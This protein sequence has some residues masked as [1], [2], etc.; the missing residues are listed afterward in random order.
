MPVV[1]T[2]HHRLHD[3]AAEIWLGVRT[4]AADT[5]ERAERIREVLAAQGAT[6]VDAKPQPETAVTSVHD[7]ALLDYLARAW[8]EWEAAGLTDDPERRCH[9]FLRA[10]PRVDFY[11]R[12]QRFPNWNLMSMDEKVA[13]ASDRITEDLA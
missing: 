2:D 12:V 11:T 4:P 1:W 10:G 9:G 5:P 13:L 8:D 3:P 6:F 7:R